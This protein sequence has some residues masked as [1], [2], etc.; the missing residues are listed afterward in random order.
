MEE[1]RDE[2]EEIILVDPRELENTEPLEEVTPVSIHPDHPDRHVMIGTGITEKLRITLIKFLKENY[3]I[4]AWSQA[5]VLGID[6]QVVTHRLFT[7]P[8]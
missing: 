7:S 6:H 8:A 4:F 2:M 5:D 3:D 1:L